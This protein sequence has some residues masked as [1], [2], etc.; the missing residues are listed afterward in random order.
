MIRLHRISPRKAL[1]FAAAALLLGALGFLYYGVII[2]D[3]VFFYF[4]LRNAKRARTANGE[5]AADLIARD[6][7]ISTPS[8]NWHRCSDCR[9]M[10]HGFPVGT[11][12]V[13]VSAIPRE[14][15]VFAFD[16]RKGLLYPADPQTKLTFPSMPE[17]PVPIREPL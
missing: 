17:S 16:T 3:E 11:I 12:R 14:N 2:N 10:E 7:H 15:Y 8:L 13:Q 4:T 6:L 5:L 9:S 1:F